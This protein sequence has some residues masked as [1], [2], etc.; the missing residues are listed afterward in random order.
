M[1]TNTLTRHY[2]DSTDNPSWIVEN[3]ETTRYTP[4]LGSGLGAVVYPDAHIE[5]TLDD[6]HGDIITTVELPTT[7]VVSGITGWS[8]FDE[9]GNAL[10]V[11]PIG[12]AE[13]SC[14]V[15]VSAS[16]PPPK[17]RR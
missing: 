12:A 8:M 17:S 13:G 5:M 7:G 9:Y 11:H 3:T 10:T 1:V 16:R 15:G 6:P 14:V 4:A 2:T